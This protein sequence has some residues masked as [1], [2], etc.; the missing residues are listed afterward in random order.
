MTDL[1][2][3]Q[4]RRVG[5]NKQYLFFTVLLP[6]LFTIFFTKIL[7][8]RM[9]AGEYQ[10]VAGATMISMMAYG[11]IGAALGATIRLAFD[12]STG[13]LRQ[14]R[15][16]PV[17]P[18][19]TFAVDVL[20]GALLVL[21]SLVVVALVGR[22]VNDV[23]L[24]LGTW[25]ALVGVLWAGSV[26]FVALGL[27]VGLALDAQAAG[28]AIGVLGTVL[29]ALGGLWIPVELF[30]S[31]MVALAHAMPSYWYAEL[32]RDVVA[33]T[34]STAPVLVLALFGALFAA[35]ALLVARR[36]PLHAVAG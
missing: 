10:D 35:A 33:G 9:P 36:R 31:G 18:G 22:F 20:V 26:V 27:A 32:G 14:L 13:W 11:A 29:A 15:V 6:A 2:L 7:G 34:P 24:G 28:A 3:F 25:V 12:R 4:L 5:R 17:P 1:L 19:A 16:T 21:P 30:P 23:Q 8:G